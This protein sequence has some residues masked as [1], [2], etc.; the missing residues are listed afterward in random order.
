MDGC[1]EGRNV[2]DELW[3]RLDECL[4]IDHVKSPITLGLVHMGSQDPSPTHV[5]KS[6]H[7]GKVPTLESRELVKKYG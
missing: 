4:A 1:G 7:G 5:T 6:Q 3:D 2:D